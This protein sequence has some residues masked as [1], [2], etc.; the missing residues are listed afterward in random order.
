MLYGE[1]LDSKR[2]PFRRIKPLAELVA[3]ILKGCEPISLSWLCLF[4]LGAALGVA[5]ALIT[6]L[7]V[8]VF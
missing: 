3:R 6:V 1:H 8:R 7:V 4:A 5:G 2:R